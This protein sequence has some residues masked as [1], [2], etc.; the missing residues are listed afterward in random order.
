MTT[1]DQVTLIGKTSL[2]RTDLAAG[3]SLT[4]TAFTGS[5]SLNAS[6]LDVSS[7]SASFSATGA[8]TAIGS[9]LVPISASFTATGTMTATG[10]GVFP[11][12][13]SLSGVGSMA[14]VGRGVG[15]GS[16]AMAGAGSMTASGAALTPG[17]GAAAL[18]GVGTMTA[19]GA[20]LTPGTGAAVLSGTGAMTAA[21]SGIGRGAAVLSASGTMTATGATANNNGQ[22]SAVLSGAGTMTVAGSG[23]GRGASVQSGTGTLTAAG[24][25][26]GRG[27]A[28]MS[29]AG[30]MTATGPGG[31]AFDPVDLF[32]GSE[33]G[34]VLQPNDTSTVF[35]ERT[36]PTTTPAIGDPVGTIQDRT[37]NGHDFTAP[38]DADRPALNASGLLFDLDHLEATPTTSGWTDMRIFVGLN[39]DNDTRFTLLAGSG[40]IA[41]VGQVNNGGGGTIFRSAGSGTCHV[42]DGASLATED[43]LYTAIF[44]QGN[45]VAEFRNVDM[46]NFSD[47]IKISGRT[48]SVHQISDDIVGPVVVI[49]E[50]ALSGTD[51][52][53]IRTWITDNM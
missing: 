6:N 11:A 10:A 47:L 28:A 42:D 7:A 23:V 36:S 35:E 52:A 34:F 25:G 13:A 15:R 46:S 39:I 43:D 8:M 14:A 22:G 17:A 4:S 31:G 16:A 20:A 48:P 29:G 50:S 12:G 3:S 41:R 51:A 18:S 30:T 45:V 5:T 26:V 37:S 27:S 32:T 44:N 9:A 33:E 38:T 49:E 24:S 53:D 19:T 40:N 21:G 2:T 1:A